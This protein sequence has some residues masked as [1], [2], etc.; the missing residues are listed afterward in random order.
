MAER[1]ASQAPERD[2]HTALVYHPLTY[3]WLCGE[4]LRRV[5]GRTIG[6][7]LAEEVAAPLGLELWIGLPPALESRVAKLQLASDWGKDHAHFDD[8][9][10][11]AIY[12][13]PPL[14]PLQELLWNQPAVHAAEIAA[15][16]AIGTARSVAR[17]Y[18]V[19]ACGG[20]VDGRRIIRAE[21]LALARTELARG[22][23]PF[24]NELMAYGVGFELQT[25]EARYGPAK[26]AFGHTGAGGS[27]HGA[28]PD[29]RVGFSYAMNELR[30]EP[31]GDAR[32]NALLG[33]LH[34]CCV[35]RG[36]S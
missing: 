26:T 12:E 32:A 13:N 4:L 18:G 28:W 3:G 35:A 23:D 34:E 19:L 31:A 22:A 7:F 1:L 8:R 17:L 15:A 14:F 9:L 27:V 16:N 36:A 30:D 10:W 33:A 6:R 11:A 2:P 29:E 24:T 25:E 21:T 20:A 5:D